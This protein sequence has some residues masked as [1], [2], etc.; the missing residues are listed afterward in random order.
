MRFECAYTELVDIDEIL[1]HPSNRNIHSQKQIEVLAKIIAKVGQRSPIVIS[2]LSG[3]IV[4][5]HGRYEAIKLLGWDKAAVDF[6]NYESEMEEL[7]DRIADNEIARYSEFDRKG[8]EFDLQDLEIDIGEFD[9]EEMGLIEFELDKPKEVDLPDLGDGSDPDIQQKTFVLSNDQA[10]IVDEAIVKMKKD[11]LYVEDGI[12]Q[13][14]NG[15][16]LSLVCQ[17]YVQS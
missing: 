15:T 6:Q 12:N 8:F 16:A 5:G 3:K 7:S 2:N 1:P 4:K 10:Q 13:N 11:K 9:F 14:S 17:L